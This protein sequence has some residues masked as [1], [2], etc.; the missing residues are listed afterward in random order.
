MIRWLDR[1][2]KDDGEVDVTRVSAL[3]DHEVELTRA[4]HVTDDPAAEATGPTDLLD[5]V[6]AL[7]EEGLSLRAYRLGQRLGPLETWK[8]TAALVLA[9]R[10]APHL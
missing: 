7:H 5:R 3:E 4:A 8:G 6:R 2:R 1:P 10:L 9:G